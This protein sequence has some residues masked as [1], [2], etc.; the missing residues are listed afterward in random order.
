VY[1]F[2]S[3]NWHSSVSSIQHADAK[4]NAGQC[5]PCLTATLLTAAATGSFRFSARQKI[6]GLLPTTPS[7]D[8]VPHH[9][10]SNTN[11]Q[12]RCTPSRL[13]PNLC[14]L[15]KAPT[16]QSRDLVHPHLLRSRHPRPVQVLIVLGAT[17]PEHP[18]PPGASAYRVWARPDTHTQT[19]MPSTKCP[20]CTALTWSTL[21][22]FTPNAN[23]QRK[24]PS[25]VWAYP[26]TSPHDF[27]VELDPITLYNFTLTPSANATKCPVRSGRI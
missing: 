26:D 1:C 13:G 24:C 22:R 27:V 19:L 18:R 9:F 15:C 3:L 10:V 11:A 5:R 14:T 6:G 20:P 25:C 16:V 2:H 23:A 8:L 21:T 12:T 17:L 4:C 7:L